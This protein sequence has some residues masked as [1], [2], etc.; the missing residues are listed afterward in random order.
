VPNGNSITFDYSGTYYYNP[1]DA[2]IIQPGDGHFGWFVITFD[3]SDGNSTYPYEAVWDFRPDLAYSEPLIPLMITSDGGGDTA[4]ITLNEGARYVTSVTATRKAGGSQSYQLI[5]GGED[6]HLF[7]LDFNG[8]SFREAPHFNYAA[9][10]DKDGI[11]E[12]EVT[13]YQSHIGEDSQLI[14]V[15]AFEPLPSLNVTVEGT[16]SA[17]LISP[18]SSTVAGPKPGNG[19]DTIFGRGGNDT[20]SGG[21][22]ADSLI[23]GTG[24]DTMTGGE[25]ADVF[26]FFLGDS[27]AGG[28][29][30]DII[31]DFQRGMDKLDLAGLHITDFE[32]QVS[33]KT[34]GSGLIVYVDTNNNGFD[35]SDFGLQLT[36]IS[37]LQQSDFL[38]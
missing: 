16:N 15:H 22:G 5:T 31:T 35:Y 34:I 9:D 28:G 38:I 25:G 19:Q 6:A 27:K 11:Y 21:A 20:V 18:A 24:K 2:D 17:D 8:L 30:R 1:N 26:H 29:T 14:Y 12:V 7:V 4:H 23:G 32:A 33:Y 13:A 36:G 37:S 3:V 10:A